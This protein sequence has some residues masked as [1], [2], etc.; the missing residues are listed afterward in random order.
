MPGR[1]TRGPKRVL[2]RPPQ[3]PHRR[4]T[5][6]QPL[7]SEDAG[8]ARRTILSILGLV[9]WVGAVLAITLGVMGSQRSVDEA[10][11]SED[12]GGEAGTT[13]QN[14]LEDSIEAEGFEI[15]SHEASEGPNLAPDFSAHT[16]SKF[17]PQ[18]CP[19]GATRKFYDVVAIRVDIVVNR[20]G[21]HDPEGYMYAL[22]DQIPAIRAQEAL[23]EDDHY[24]LS[25]GIGADAI[26]PLTIR[27][28]EGDCVEIAFENQLTEPATLT[29]HGADMVL[30][31]TGDPALT[32]NPDTSANPG[33]SVVLE[34]YIDPQYYGENTHYLHSHGARD[35]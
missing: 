13:L 27:A 19:L 9:V 4:A 23:G 34:W 26:Q 6:N 7:V 3:E 1:H 11:A 31:A 33:E 15:S 25:L 28:N 2:G 14:N 24:G 30:S 16:A 12:H 32:T 5:R 21:D 18:S 22:R 10:L 17:Q 35:R 29:V 20:W 8:R